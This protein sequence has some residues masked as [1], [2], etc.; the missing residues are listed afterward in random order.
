MMR[1]H[2]HRRESRLRIGS[3]V[4]SVAVILMIS[5]GVSG[6][7]RDFTRDWLIGFSVKNTAK[8]Y[9]A[10]SDFERLKQTNT[11]RLSRMTTDEYR[12]RY[13]RFYSH[14]SDLPQSLKMAYGI[15]PSLDRGGAV[16]RI[17][18]MRKEDLYHLIDRIPDEFIT[19]RFD[20][21]CNQ[22]HGSGKRFSLE[23]VLEFWNTIR[24]QIE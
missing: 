11:E 14:L 6:K 20:Q 7:D 5:T 8:A 16:K 24:K 22:P 15:V 18:S 10:V 13:A 17:E 2:D 12:A 9:V 4:L 3:I 19:R 1:P 23:K 21:Y